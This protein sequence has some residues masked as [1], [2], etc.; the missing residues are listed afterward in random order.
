MIMVEAPCDVCALNQTLAMKTMKTTFLLIRVVGAFALTFS[1]TSWAETKYVDQRYG[2]NGDGTMAKPYET[3]QKAIDDNECT[4]VVVYPGTYTEN[5]LI[6]KSIRIYGYDG[7]LTTRIDGSQGGPQR[8]V[9]TIT[10]QGLD[11]RIEGLGISSG[12]YGVHQENAGVLSLRNCI[13]C[14]N[15][16][17]GL[18]LQRNAVNQ[19]VRVYLQN[20]V[21][22]HNTGSGI[23]LYSGPVGYFPTLTV[24]NC[25]FSSNTRYGIEDNSVSY[26]WDHWGG[27]V[28]L[29]YNDFADNGLGKYTRVFDPG[30]QWGHGPHELSLSPSFV[31]GASAD[32]GADF[33]LLPNSPCKD[34]GDPGVGF[35]DPD[36]TRNDIGAYGG[37]GARTFFT[38]PNDGPIVRDVIVKP[39]IIPKG[40]TFTIKARGT[41]R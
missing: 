20:C 31:G 16:Q 12:R 35:L 27:P 11:V 8:D 38:S 13:L 17:H 33:R 4:E 39:S 7:P 26:C 30:C 36:G 37:P 15:A 19:D 18:Y 1:A 34:A 22:T 3:I 9:I 41:I 10:D 14:G 25:I 21:L 29:D 2:P 6:G 24:L 5:L 32:C 23:Y 28:E 40:E